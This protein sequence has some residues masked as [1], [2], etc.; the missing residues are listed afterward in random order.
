MFGVSPGFSFPPNQINADCPRPHQP[1]C[2]FLT[3]N[4]E[5][6]PPYPAG[7]APHALMAGSAPACV[8]LS[9]T[10]DVLKQLPS[11]SM[12]CGAW[13]IA[14]TIPPALPWWMALRSKRENAPDEL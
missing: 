9:D 12:V 14:A 6:S 4:P 3:P 8:A 2:A 11:Y 5:T 13:N 1:F 10:S 7:C